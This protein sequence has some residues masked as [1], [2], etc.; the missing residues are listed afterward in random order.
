M[1]N[2]SPLNVTIVRPK[3]K[4]PDVGAA[5]LGGIIAFLIRAALIMWASAHISLVPDLG[6]LEALWLSFFVSLFLFRSDTTYRVW[7]R[8]AS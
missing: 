7:T 4:A 2:L 1:S 8:Q 3:L 5:L 6:Y